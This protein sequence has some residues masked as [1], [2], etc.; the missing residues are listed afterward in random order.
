MVVDWCFSLTFSSGRLF[1]RPPDLSC[2][3]LTAG[4]RWPSRWR[5]YVEKIVSSNGRESLVYI[6]VNYSKKHFFTIFNLSNFLWISFTTKQLSNNDFQ[7]T[8]GRMWVLCSHVL[9]FYAGEFRNSR[10]NR[11]VGEKHFVQNN[12]FWCFLY[13][14]GLEVVPLKQ[15]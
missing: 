13:V 1:L 2:K 9:R 14:G 11:V 5:V 10:C 3:L 12:P 7:L 6:F 4:V 15:W 8:N